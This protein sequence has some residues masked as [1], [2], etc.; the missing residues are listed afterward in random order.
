ML[1]KVDCQNLLST[2]L[3]QVVSTSSNKSANDKVKQANAMVLFVY[4]PD[5][6]LFHFTL[7]QQLLPDN[8]CKIP[9][10]ENAMNTKTIHRRFTN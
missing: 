4:K 1:L 6:T 8:L 9:S 5:D 10:T 3:L 2:A 7:S